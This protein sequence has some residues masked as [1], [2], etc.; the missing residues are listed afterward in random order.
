MFPNDLND[1]H[2]YL[3]RKAK[4][5]FS[6]RSLLQSLLFYPYGSPSTAL[7]NSLP[8]TLPLGSL[9]C[10]TKP[11]WKLHQPSHL[12]STEDCIPKASTSKHFYKP[13][14]QVCGGKAP[15]G[16]PR[17]QLVPP[18]TPTADTYHR[19]IR[20]GQICCSLFSRTFSLKQ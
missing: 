15:R 13:R 19:V 1:I 6:P 12:I 16:V 8:Q 4:T 5:Y 3:L 18:T 2:A 17:K 7:A 9:W 10:Q 14:E 20:S 11:N